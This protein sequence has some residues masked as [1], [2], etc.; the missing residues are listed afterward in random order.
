MESAKF[1]NCF[2]IIV[3]QKIQKEL[4][5]LVNKLFLYDIVFRNIRYL[6]FAQVT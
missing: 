3:F 4:I 2:C 6:S 1:N 5:N